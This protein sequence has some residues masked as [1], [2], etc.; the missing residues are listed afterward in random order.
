[1]PS[2]AEFERL[3]GSRMRASN[4]IR[5][6]RCMLSEYLLKNV[7]STTVPDDKKHVVIG[8]KYHT[9]QFFPSTEK[10]VSSA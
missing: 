2:I 9:H 3:I 7:I 1:M 8:A 5:V 4:H 10:L 6:F